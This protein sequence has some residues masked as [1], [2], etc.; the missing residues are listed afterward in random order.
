M[1]GCGSPASRATRRCCTGSGC[2][3]SR[4]QRLHPRWPSASRTASG[5]PRSAPRAGR[6]RGSAVGN[7]R[8]NRSWADAR[9]AGVSKK[10]STV[11]SGWAFPY[12]P[13]PTDPNRHCHP[14]RTLRTPCSP[15]L[16]DRRGSP[17]ACSPPLLPPAQPSFGV[18]DAI[19]RPT[20]P[21]QDNTW[22]PVEN[23]ANA[24]ELI[25]EYN[26]QALSSRRHGLRTG[27]GTA[28][29]KVSHWDLSLK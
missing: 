22:E 6:V 25:R 13:P 12:A 17:P 18:N 2:S 7:G 19:A 20:A 10:S 21:T 4:T 28:R 26:R 15:N 8:Y 11:F 5:L 14:A 24:G 16:T 23:L 3:R 9:R 1:S 29:V 27:K